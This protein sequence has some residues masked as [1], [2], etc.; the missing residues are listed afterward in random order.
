MTE[1]LSVHHT[2][3]VA[4]PY[5]ALLFFPPLREPSINAINLPSLAPCDRILGLPE[6]GCRFLGPQSLNWS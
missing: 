6:W 4:E 3:Q 1:Q 2:T 5:L